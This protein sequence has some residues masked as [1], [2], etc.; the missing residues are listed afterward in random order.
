MKVPRR[1]WMF[2][3][4]TQELAEYSTV[5]TKHRQCPCPSSSNPA[6]IA[7]QD[8]HPLHLQG[9]I[10]RSRLAEAYCA[11]NIDARLDVRAL[12]HRRVVVKSLVLE[13]PVINL[14]SDPDGPWNFENPG[15]K[16]T[17]GT[18]LFGV[19]SRVEIKRARVIASNL[20]PS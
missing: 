5:E 14:V 19:V 15:T 11:S 10:Y 9:N 7:R 3:K 1:I 18:L 13:Q 4:A 6:S 16:N 17:P 8:D 12:L 2:V 20:L